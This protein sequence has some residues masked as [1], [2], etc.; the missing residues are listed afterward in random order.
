[1][2]YKI[3]IEI[4][5]RDCVRKIYNANGPTLRYGWHGFEQR[6]IDN[7]T[8]EWCKRLSSLCSCKRT[9]FLVFSLTADSTFVHF[10]V[11]IWWKLQ[12]SWCYCVEYLRIS[13]FL[14]FYISQGSVATQLRFGKKYHNDFIANFLLN[15]KVKEFFKIG[16]YLPTLSTNNVG[17][18][19]SGPPCTYTLNYQILPDSVMFKHSEAYWF[20]Q[21][22]Q[23]YVFKEMLQLWLYWCTD[24]LFPLQGIELFV[25]SK[26]VC[27][28]SVRMHRVATFMLSVKNLMSM[29]VASCHYI[30]ILIFI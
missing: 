20:L 5:Q 11:L 4:E 2:N 16:Q 22:F 1:M 18:V 9:T 21:L 25:M 23:V 19:Q 26:C 17:V 12:I 7:A 8:D 24:I 14:F 6:I 13:H 10:N 29:F 15:P 30:Y 27:L 3:C 28:H